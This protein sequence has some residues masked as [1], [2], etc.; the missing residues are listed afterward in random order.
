MPPRVR[1]DL[2]S[3]KRARVD[4]STVG[5]A[6]HSE[7]PSPIDSRFFDR[8]TMSACKRDFHAAK[9]FPHLRLTEFCDE[10]RMCAIREEITGRL[11]A[12]FK[13]TDLY[14]VRAINAPLPLALSPSR[15]AVTP[16]E[17]NRRLDCHRPPAS[18]AEAAAAAA[19]QPEGLALH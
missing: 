7:L 15:D 8:K 10:E 18:G 4:I 19:V 2:G 9:P 6:A 12:K 17:P 16:G 1:P 11:H 3:H 5:G 13:E 14:K